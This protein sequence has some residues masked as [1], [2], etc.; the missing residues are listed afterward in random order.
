[1][2]EQFTERSQKVMT[3]AN[4]EAHR[5]NHEYI[6]SEHLLLWLVEEARDALESLGVNAQEVRVELRK[7]W[8]SGH[9]QVTAGERP[10]TPRARRIIEYAIKESL[11]LKHV[12]VEPEHL[13]LGL[14]HEQYAV[15]GQILLTLNVKLEQIRGRL[16]RQARN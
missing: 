16:E 12:G 8:K 7:T 2:Y 1:M 5:S 11:D 3:R 13:L 10:L 14:A 15:S 9:T 4:E 6:G